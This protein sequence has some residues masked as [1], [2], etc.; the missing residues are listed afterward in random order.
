MFGTGLN[1]VRDCTRIFGTN[2]GR[3]SVPPGNPPFRVCPTEHT[4]ANCYLFTTECRYNSTVLP[5]CSTAQ[6]SVSFLLNATEFYCAVRAANHFHI[7]VCR[8]TTD[9]TVRSVLRL[10]RIFFTSFSLLHSAVCRQ[11]RQHCVFCNA[12]Y[13]D[14]R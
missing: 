9:S 1:I 13:P 10:V 12:L 7:P 8:H 11:Y 6:C 2:S 3:L 14:I 5:Y 4:L